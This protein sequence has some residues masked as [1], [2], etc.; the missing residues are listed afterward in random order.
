MPHHHH[1]YLAPVPSEQA[2]QPSLVYTGTVSNSPGWFNQWHCHDFC[3]IL[4]VAS[5]TGTLVLQDGEHP[6]KAGRLVIYNPGVYHEERSDEAS[7]LVLVFLAVQ[8]FATPGLAQ[9]HLL[10]PED[11]PIVKC[12]HHNRLIASYFDALLFESMVQQPYYQQIAQG[13]LLAILAN[14]TRLLDERQQQTEDPRQKS[15]KVKQYLEAHYD[16]PITLESLSEAVYISKHY[17]AHMFKE[18]VGVSPIRYLTTL[19]MGKAQ[20]LLRGTS[21]S[22]RE[23][24]LQLSYEDPQYFSQVFKKTF[25]LTPAQYR[26]QHTL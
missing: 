12:G 21:L 22:I 6:L 18:H 4:Y 13:L 23:I 14:A 19:R 25:G 2:N 7:P 16:K 10:A 24:A 5:G 15:G 17:L 1:Y 26:K 9:N 20:D 3:E 8:G 11:F